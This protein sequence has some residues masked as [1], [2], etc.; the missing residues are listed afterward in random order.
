MSQTLEAPWRP[1]EPSPE[2]LYTPDDVESMKGELQDLHEDFLNVDVN[3]ENDTESGHKPF[4]RLNTYLTYALKMKQIGAGKGIT[5]DTKEVSSYL[6]KVW[7]EQSKEDNYNL[8]ENM[9]FLHSYALLRQLGSKAKLSEP[10]QKILRERLDK[11]DD[12]DH[13]LRYAV[14]LKHVG[15][16]KEE[17]QKT[18]FEQLQSERV[19]TNLSHRDEPEPV[20]MTSLRTARID[21]LL[22]QEEP[23]RAAVEGMKEKVNPRVKQAVGLLEKTGS[24]R[25]LTLQLKRGQSLDPTLRPSAE[26]YVGITNDLE[27]KKNNRTSGWRSWLQY[28]SNWVRM[29][30]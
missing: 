3:G 6:N 25:D 2:S 26:A 9:D 12:V 15:L 18:V 8:D 7:K 23:Y 19:F 22:G 24:W 14:N 16:F 30:K 21:F 1:T 28:A 29:K 13:A 27:A 5:I 20:E 4:E 10:V 11:Y 17:E